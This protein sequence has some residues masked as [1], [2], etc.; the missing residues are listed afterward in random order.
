MSSWHSIVSQSFPS[1]MTPHMNG[2]CEFSF[3]MS[4]R[5]R[6]VSEASSPGVKV[7]GGE[8]ESV[9]VGCGGGEGG[10]KQV[11]RSSSRVV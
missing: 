8:G 7:G 3:A 10:G 6:Q 1:G 2:S 4:K 11:E 9:L 5:L